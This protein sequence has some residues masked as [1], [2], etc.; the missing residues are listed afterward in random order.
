[1][2]TLALVVTIGTQPHVSSVLW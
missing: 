2:E 1:M